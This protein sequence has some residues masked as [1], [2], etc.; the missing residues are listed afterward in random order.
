[1]KNNNYKRKYQEEDSQRTREQC[2]NQNRIKAQE[3]VII[4]LQKKYEKAS[5]DADRYRKRIAQLTEAMPV[6]RAHIEK[7]NAALA[8]MTARLKSIE[9]QLKGEPK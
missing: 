7:V 3:I 6:Y 5:H 4:E 1:M 2:Y 9:E 8:E